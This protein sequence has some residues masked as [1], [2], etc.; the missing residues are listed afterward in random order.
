MLTDTL[1]R[2]DSF[3]RWLVR[4]TFCGAGGKQFA[5]ALNLKVRYLFLLYNIYF[6]LFT[7][8]IYLFINI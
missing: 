5:C 7:I 6:Y 4:Y 8:S 1:L 2:A 3:A